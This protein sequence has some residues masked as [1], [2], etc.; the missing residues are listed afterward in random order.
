M[1]DYNEARET[2][3]TSGHFPTISGRRKR[4]CSHHKPFNMSRAK[5]NKERFVPLQNLLFTHPV[6]LVWV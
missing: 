4:S 6:S 3:N 1:S 5:A 2:F